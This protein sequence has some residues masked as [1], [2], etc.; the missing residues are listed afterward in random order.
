MVS[1]P[2]K[3]SIV[4]IVLMVAI[5]PSMG[6]LKV[7][8]EN[9]TIIGAD[10][11][12]IV[13]GV[14]D[15]GFITEVPYKISLTEKVTLTWTNKPSDALPWK[16]LIVTR[17]VDV[18]I[19]LGDVRGEE[20]RIVGQ[21]AT[22]KFYDFNDRVGNIETSYVAGNS[23]MTKDDYGFLTYKS[24]YLKDITL[25]RSND[26]EEAPIQIVDNRSVA[27]DY[28]FNPIAPN[29]QFI[30]SYPQ[31]IQYGEAVSN[32]AI[33]PNLLD[34]VEFTDLSSMFNLKYGINLPDLGPGEVTLA[35]F[36]LNDRFGSM[37]LGNGIITDNIIPISP[38][39]FTDLK[40][41]W[42]SLYE[43]AA[44]GYIAPYVVNE[45]VFYI[46]INN[47]RGEPL[48]SVKLSIPVPMI[49]RPINSQAERVIE[50]MKAH[51]IGVNT[52]GT[53]SYTM[54]FKD[55]DVLNPMSVLQNFPLTDTIKIFI[56]F[57]R[58]LSHFKIIDV[59]VSALGAHIY[60]RYNT[61]KVSHPNIAVAGYS[62]PILNAFIETID[63]FINGIRKW[64]GYM[65]PSYTTN[66]NLVQNNP[67]YKDNSIGSFKI[68]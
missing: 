55:K 61:D 31:N 60:D 2:H 14:N 38:F 46:N 35:K 5:I 15:V 1:I 32:F 58:V 47:L 29:M 66:Y 18:D 11:E 19:Q 54:T 43:N 34:E 63:A 40:S 12:S 10:A 33:D 28:A 37:N 7:A 23:I 25:T 6:C 64:T 52:V 4:S 48:T 39:H 26:T 41:R 13:K 22:V 30:S 24:A 42:E 45:V 16:K 20:D 21:S 17:V 8:P 44:P 49:L 53:Y 50:Y 59:R 27:T 56:P 57:K 51:N 62:F 3:I 67:N 65:D 36:N 9:V 68:I